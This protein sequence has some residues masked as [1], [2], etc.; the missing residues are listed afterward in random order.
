[1]FSPRKFQ[2]Q[3]KP[4]F[5]E[6]MVPKHGFDLHTPKSESERKL[7]TTQPGHDEV[8]KFIY[9]KQAKFMFVV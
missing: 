4:I 1:M 3:Q 7:K 9:H 2:K 8:D 5:F 6:L